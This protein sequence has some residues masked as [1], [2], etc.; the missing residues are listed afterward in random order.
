MF[1]PLSLYIGLRYTRAKRR[2]GFISFISLTSMIGIALGVAVLITVLSVMNGFDLHIREGIFSLAPQVSVTGNNEKI[3]DWQSLQKQLSSLPNVSA[4][5][6]YINGQGI[7]KSGAIVAPVM[8]T[9]IDPAQQGKIT[10][11][12]QKMVTGKLTDLRPGQFGVILGESLA[13]NL[14]AVVGSKV[15]LITPEMS[16]TPAGITPRFKRFTVVGIFNAGGGFGFDSR[17]AFI[18]LHDAQA[19]FMYGSSVTG[20]NI[21]IPDPYMAISV[22]Q[23]LQNAVPDIYVSN[24]TQQYGP[25]FKAIALE[26]TMMFLILLL[27][28]AVAAFNLVST[29]VMV[30]ND[31]Q[32]DIAILRTYGATPG[33][34]MRIFMV[35]GMIVGLV[36]TLLGLIGGVLI[37]WNVTAI[38][39]GIQ[40]ILGV[41]LFQSSVYLVSELPSKLELSDLIQICLIAVTLSLVATI[42]PAWRASR[43][44]P[45]E[46]LRYE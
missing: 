2:N 27:I 4:S 41:Q 20:L 25:F 18:E 1:K 9:G 37:A 23:E 3:D 33:L 30:V 7:L 29:L 5:A 32:A 6:P 8:V 45:A 17:L 42:Y 21:K 14:G 39:N 24:W 12:P 16:V 34:I 31:K 19:M 13:N 15:M 44:Q 38:V 46:A 28:V 22:S 40:N 35:Q 11:L 36:G 26:K 10:E 43:T